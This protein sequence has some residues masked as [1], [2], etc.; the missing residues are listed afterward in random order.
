MSLHTLKA[1]AAGLNAATAAEQVTSGMDLLVNAAANNQV[2]LL[3][4]AI[5][6]QGVPADLLLQWAPPGVYPRR[7]TLLM[8]AAASG[9]IEAVHYLLCNGANPDAQ[10]PDDGF[11]ALHCAAESG[12]ARTAEII[13]VV[14]HYG[15]CR[16]A[17]DMSGRRPVD[18][19]SD[20]IDAGQGAMFP[21]SGEVGVSARPSCGTSSL[22]HS[23]FLG[24]CGV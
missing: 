2:Q 8:I 21:G 9:C 13:A 12:H 20:L 18:L 11:T 1:W 17:V 5:E 23:L 19:L 14:L 22:C 3:K 4:H 10:S 6:V 16:D 7:R 15:G 24:I